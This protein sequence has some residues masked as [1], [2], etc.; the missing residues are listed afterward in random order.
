[1]NEEEK[2]KARQEEKEERE[3]FGGLNVLKQDFKIMYIKKEYPELRNNPH[4]TDSSYAL[5]P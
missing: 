4:N 5:Y 3:K 2:R 1:M